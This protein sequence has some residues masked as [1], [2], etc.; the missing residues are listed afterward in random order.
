MTTKSGFKVVKLAQILI[1]GKKMLEN[2]HFWHDDGVTRRNDVILE[3]KKCFHCIPRHSSLG[4]DAKMTTKSGFKVVKLAQMLIFD[5][6]ILEN[7][8]L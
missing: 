6:E 1:F 5:Q 8:H 7:G 4:L 3:L 2:G